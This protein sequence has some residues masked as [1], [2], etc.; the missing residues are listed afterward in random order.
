P[1]P[2][3]TTAARPTTTDTTATTAP[4][5]DGTVG[6]P[7]TSV[8]GF[9]SP[10][11]AAMAFATDVLGFAEPT[12]TAEGAGEVEVRSRPTAGATTTIAVHDTG[13]RG[14][15]VT[16]ARS[17]QGRIDTPTAGDAVDLP[18][19]VE[20]EATAFEATLAV[21]LLALDGTTIAATTTMAGANG[22]VGP[23]ATTIDVGPGADPAGGPT[24]VLIGE[25][26]ASGEGDLNWAAVVLVDL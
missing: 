26:D 25:G 4:A 6:W 22:E 21:R 3:T 8:G 13:A 10:M 15:V 1:P 9:D 23:F 11:E 18:V 16:G 7:G 12:V 24:F 17:P 2:P 5:D 20:G 19:T 14:W